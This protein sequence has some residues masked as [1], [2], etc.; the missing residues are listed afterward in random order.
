MIELLRKK[1]DMSNVES[2]IDVINTFDH[3]RN[4]SLWNWNLPRK[5][6]WKSSVRKII[7]NDKWVWSERIENDWWSLDM[8]SC[9]EKSFSI[10]ERIKIRIGFCIVNKSFNLWSIFPPSSLMPKPLDE[11]M[12]QENAGRKNARIDLRSDRI[13]LFWNFRKSIRCFSCSS[14]WYL[15]HS[16]VSVTW[17]G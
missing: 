4:S 15:F 11:P 16:K 12:S 9:D 10:S 7:S 5:I 13:D 8:G 6:K 17:F 3:Y 14:R 1:F 2:M